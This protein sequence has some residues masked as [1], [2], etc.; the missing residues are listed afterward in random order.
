MDPGRAEN[1]GR[2]LELVHESGGAIALDEGTRVAQS[3]LSAR[4]GRED[5][6]AS[7]VVLLLAEQAGR[8]IRGQADDLQVV[9]LD[10]VQVRIEA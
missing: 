3:L 4:V 1:G 7:G 5:L 2:V 8:E 10:V 6:L 9:S